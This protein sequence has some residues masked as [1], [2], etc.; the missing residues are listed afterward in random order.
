MNTNHWMDF[1]DS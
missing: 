1:A